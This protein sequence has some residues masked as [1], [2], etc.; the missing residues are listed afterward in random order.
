[1]APGPARHTTVLAFLREVAAEWQRD[2][3]L[4]QGAA[5][6]YY[7]LFSLAPLLVVVIAM[8]GLVLGDAAA[9][10]ELVARI[11]GAVGP[12]AAKVIEGMVVAASR[13]KSGLIATGASLATMA[14]GASG[15]F[16]QLRSSLNHIWGVP[17]G[18]RQGVH[19]LVMQR[20]AAFGIIL[21]IGS[22]LLVSL[23]LSAILAAVHDVVSRHLPLLAVLLP[24]LNLLLSYL[25]ATAFFALIYKVLPDARMRWRDVWT[26]AA[27]TALL[28]TGGKSMIAFYL[29]YASGTSV[30]GAAAS[31]VVL[32]LWIYYSAQVL[33]L[34]AEFTEV[35]S[36]RYGSRG[37][38]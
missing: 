38:A 32:L 30:Y 10:G 19:G 2:N 31:L 25:V 17:A 35:Y 34:G 37:G 3:A 12:E 14:F 28:F 20:L 6:A 36:R 13:P 4:S 29:G 26:G 24:P 23:A 16:G 22:L 33:L 8:A 18:G 1:M 11:G 15:V 21:G 27:V 7:A 9:Q 5:L